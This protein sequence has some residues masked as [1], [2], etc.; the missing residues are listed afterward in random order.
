MMKEYKEGDIVNNVKPFQRYIDGFELGL[1][2]KIYDKDSIVE[3]VNDLLAAG[4]LCH[5]KM[6]AV[7][8]RVLVENN[9]HMKV[10]AGDRQ[11][12]VRVWGKNKNSLKLLSWIK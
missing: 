6:G 9:C 5:E 1:V 7:L 10:I 12:I 2:V 11:C 8:V 3:L 4:S